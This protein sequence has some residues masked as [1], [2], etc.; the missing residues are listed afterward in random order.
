MTTYTS[1]GYSPKLYTPQEI[2]SMSPNAMKR[3]L[4]SICA[5]EPEM[6]DKIETVLGFAPRW[7]K[8]TTIQYALIALAWI[9]LESK[10]HDLDDQ[11]CFAIEAIT[12]CIGEV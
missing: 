8:M 10:S 7:S 5:L 1:E 3:T 2:L 12:E 6:A 9:Y 4:S 11:V